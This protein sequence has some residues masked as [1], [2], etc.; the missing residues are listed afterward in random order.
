MRP[1]DRER[2]K[3]IYEKAAAVDLVK[4]FRNIPRFHNYSLG[5]FILIMLQNP[6]ASQ[7]AGFHRWKKYERKVKKGE[8]GLVILAPCVYKWKQRKENEETGE[9][10]E[11]EFKELRGFKTA[12]VWDI[13]QTEGKELPPMPYAQESTGSYSLGDYERVRDA[14]SKYYPVIERP[15]VYGQ[16][17]QTDG[18]SIWINSRNP[19][20][21]RFRTM[22]HELGHILLDHTGDRK[23][24]SREQMESE[25]EL[26]CSY[27]T[28]RAVISTTTRYI[29]LAGWTRR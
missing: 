9:E 20:E 14:V 26:F 16:G 23:D 27:W 17:G 12:H 1:R 8:K 18:T 22:F 6:E 2:L 3:Q 5:N 25:A 4:L 24:I 10:D 15:A 19:E 13:S 11:I 29:S 28:A 21:H 7:V